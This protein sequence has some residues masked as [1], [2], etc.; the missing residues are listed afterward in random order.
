MNRCA[1][2]LTLVLAPA[3]WAAA[4]RPKPKKAGIALARVSRKGDKTTAPVTLTLTLLPARGGQQP[5]RITALPRQDGDQLVLQA[6]ASDGLAI[7]SGPV[8]REGVPRSGRPLTLELVLRA[9]RP[10]AHSLVITATF[11]RGGKNSTA[12]AQ[13]V[14]NGALLAPEAEHAGARRVRHPDGRGLTEI[15]AGEP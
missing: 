5:V 12:V 9:D 6:E 3:V 11:T 8:E 1:L 15:P 7:A 13:Y 4:P 10:G 14:E 2:L